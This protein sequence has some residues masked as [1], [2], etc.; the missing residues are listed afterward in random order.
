[1]RLSLA[2]SIALPCI[3]LGSPVR[4]EDG[5]PPP[6]SATAQTTSASPAYLLR[7][8]G[9]EGDDTVRVDGDRVTVVSDGRGPRTAGTFTGALTKEQREE[10][11]RALADLRTLPAPTEADKKVGPGESRMTLEFL[12]ADGKP[13]RLQ[14]NTHWIRNPE[15][16]KKLLG[17][18]KF[19]AVA[20][21]I[22]PPR[23]EPV[24]FALASP[25]GTNRLDVAA[26]GKTSTSVT[27]NGQS[28]TFVGQLDDAERQR[29]L[30]ARAQL[31][32]LPEPTAD[33]LKVA[34]GEPSMELSFRDALGVRRSFK[35]NPSY[36]APN[37][38]RIAPLMGFM[39]TTFQRLSTQP[40]ETTG[41]VGG[42]TKTTKSP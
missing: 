41:L 8:E 5:L 2:I 14:V 29:L 40:A 34:P 3:L 42:V 30:A 15:V 36:L 9:P 38:A 23:F 27:A 12:G 16:A 11:D 33:Q 32:S 20:D 25:Q 31:L 18:A 39:E 28:F 35:V 17:A 21:R 4:A 6:V 22:A 19:S 26:D 24:T 10:L 37:G 1:M 7:V 13:R